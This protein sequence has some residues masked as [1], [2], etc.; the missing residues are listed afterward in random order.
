M[1]KLKEHGVF[2]AVMGLLFSV[3]IGGIGY[4]EYI[5][6]HGELVILETAPV[7]PR[8]IFRG[9]YVI[10]RYLI[11]EEAE[12]RLELRGY[13]AGQPVYIEV[14]S[15]ATSSSFSDATQ[16]RPQEGLYIQAEVN[17]RQGEPRVDMPSLNQF[18][19]PEGKGLAIERMR[20]ELLVEVSVKNGQARILRLL[21]NDGEEIDFSAI[22][23]EDFRGWW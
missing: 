12:E 11:E 13:E 4:Q 8:D 18:Y 7:D 9:D 1:K 2:V 14:S 15:T 10:L 16:Q 20:N 6:R 23:Q 19:V 21:D 17:E 3:I 22:E 5:L